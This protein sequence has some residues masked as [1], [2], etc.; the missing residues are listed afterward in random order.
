[1]TTQIPML[2]RPVSA[3]ELGL[4]PF[5]AW[6]VDELAR[7]KVAGHARQILCSP[8]GSGKTEIAIHLV[9][10][11]R[12]RDMRIAFVCDRRV[13]VKQTSQRFAKY[14]IPHGVSMAKKS[15]GRS[16]PIQICSAQTIEKRGYWPALDLLIIDECFH[17]SVEILTAIGWRRF[18]SLAEGVR[19][20][21]WTEDGIEFVVPAQYIRR[22]FDGDLIRLH[23]DALADL[24]MTPN[25]ELLLHYQASDLYKKEAVAHAKFNSHKRIPVA[26]RSVAGGPSELTP[27]ERLMIALQADGNLHHESDRRVCTLAFS[28]VKQRKIDRLHQICSDGGFHIKEVADADRSPR[29][30]F[31]VYAIQSA[32]KHLDLHFELASI[33]YEKARAVITEM[34]EWDGSKLP[35]DGLYYSSTDESA[36]DFYQAVAVLAGYKARQTLQ[37]DSRSDSFSDVHRLFISPATSTITTQALKRDAEH[38]TGD[39]YCVRVPSGNIVVRRNGKVLV[40]GNCHTQRKGVLEFAKNWGGPVIGLT[41]TPLT[42][43]LGNWYSKVVNAVTTDRLLAD[44]YLAP[45]KIYAATEIDMAGAKKGND[46]EWLRS[47]VRTRGRPIIGD[48]VSTYERMTHQHFGGPVKTLL[49][50]ADVAHGEELCRAFQAAGHDFRQS[51]Y[52]DSTDETEAMVEGFRRGD[53]MGLASV[54]KFVKGFDVPDVLCMIGARPYSSSLASVIQQMG[55][56]MRTAEGKEFCLYLDHSGNVAGWYDDVMEF[57]ANGVDRLDTAEKR[58]PKR[59]EGEDRPDVV[60]DCGF[61]LQTGMQS[62]PSCGAA[63]RKRRTRT[64]MV[65]GRME[66]WAPA[67]PAEWMKDEPWVWSQVCRLALDHKGGD[68]EAARKSAAGYYKGMY[69]RWPQWGRPLNPCREPVDERVSKR[70]KY[71][72]IRFAKSRRAA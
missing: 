33:G 71:N 20:A 1:M 55:R 48:I 25:H 8:T 11:A 21:Q 28:F 16:M 5:Q 51:T 41:A 68:M 44:G 35:K 36:V 22:H 62:C 61:V 19:V 58:K 23:S 63:R 67:Q 24:S 37:E 53:F 3:G 54:E 38:Y 13:L 47:E 29:R 9:T 12:K 66:E 27:F 56:G 26:G 39:V 18:D 14:G 6:A 4:Y 17:P 60:C 7:G 10:R 52:R 50:S 32:S 34:A 43:G 70:V 40:T 49:F 46:G 65:P 15:F 45:L 57:W 30:R 69:G 2:D 59:R 64:E 72:L 31:M 42:E